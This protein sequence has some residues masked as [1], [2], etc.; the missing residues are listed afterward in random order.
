MLISA[1]ALAIMLFE[2]LS[3]PL[4]LSDLRTPALYERVAAEPGDFALL[5][6][7]PGWRN[8]ARV[9]GKVDTLI[10]QQ[11]WN[12]TSHGKRVL[13]GNTSRNPEFKFQYFSENPTLALLIALTN[14][15]DL[16]QHVAL[17]EE[18]AARPITDEDRALAGDLAAMLRIRYVMVH[19]DKV[20]PET[21]Q[22]LRALLPLDL[23]GEDGSLALYRI[24]DDRTAPRAFRLG[25]DA[26]RVV[27]AE[28][29]SP[30]AG[31]PGVY[32]QRS[33]V[34]LLL[35]LP[36]EKTK[37]RLKGRSLAPSQQVSLVVNGRE[38]AS[39]FMPD[40]PSWLALDVP[41]EPERP[42][43]SDVR[44]RF[45][46]LAPVA[47]LAEGRWAVGGTGAQSPVSILARSAGEETGDFAHLYVDGVDL[48][49]DERGY[50]LVALDP[51][52]GD[53]VAQAAFD[54]HADPT[55][56]SRLAAWVAG[57]PPGS[58]VAGAVRDEASM[59]LPEEALTALRSLGVADD[60]SGR[61]RWSHAFIGAAGAPA[62]SAVEALDGIRPAQ[63]SVGLPVS[64]PQ[65]AAWLSDVAVGE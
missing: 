21:E 20:P 14:A 38:I 52:Y 51:L 41:G 19:R 50:N 40:E 61:F 39:A 65:V 2:H 34:R 35:P 57:L 48:S 5:E 12:Q 27:L 1:I 47:E 31:E 28:G 36:A 29:W 24:T 49:L 11:L 46:A 37:I 23:V 53:V 33:E 4:P 3:I 56:G 44:L 42:P 64:A 32:A 30:P 60:L 45:S 26:S 9:A 58:I 25:D 22:A 13:G 55:A 7:P 10:M 8:G 59:S 18:L 15:A 62:G 43:L 6:V 17:R 54:T 16:P 63:V